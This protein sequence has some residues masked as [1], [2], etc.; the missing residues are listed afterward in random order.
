MRWVSEHKKKIIWVL[1]GIL[2]ASFSAWLAMF[3]LDASQSVGVS[4]GSF[5]YPEKN[6]TEQIPNYDFYE[7]LGSSMP[8]LKPESPAVN[9]AVCIYCPPSVPPLKSESPAVSTS[10]RI[11]SMVEKTKGNIAFNV[12][13]ALNL[14]DT[15]IIQLK[16]GLDTPIDQLSE[17]IAA[18]G[19]KEGAHIEVSDR[20]E[21]SLK[22]SNFTVTPVTPE[23]SSH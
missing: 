20:M 17:M 19:K 5:K 11:D 9:Q 2:F 1:V 18:P 3:E 13:E 14:D 4:G 22:S 6:P 15:A 21:A 8:P 23:D 10:E 12:P 7:I 16:L